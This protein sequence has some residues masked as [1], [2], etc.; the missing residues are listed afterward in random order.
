MAPGKPP[1]RQ[2]DGPGRS[3]AAGTKVPEG[4]F[5]LDDATE[6]E[7]IKFN[8]YLAAQ[9]DLEA[10]ERRVR[11]AERAKDEAAA[12]VRELASDPQ[13]TKEQ[14]EEAEQAYKEALAKLRALRDGS[15]AG[16]PAAEVAAPGDAT[17]G[18]DAASEALVDEPT[19]ESGE[20]ATPIGT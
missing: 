7:L 15:E 6:A 4:G 16:P 8:V 18:E 14:R 3:P 2:G 11:K 1:A 5:P 9:Q 19:A 13:A 12:R 20:D 17:R 10:R